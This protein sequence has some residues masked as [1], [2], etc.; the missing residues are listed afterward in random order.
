MVKY[1]VMIYIAMFSAACGQVL[2]KKG[3]LPSVTRK[4]GP[5]LNGWVILGLGAMILSMLL[6]VRGLR[7]VPLRDMV[8]ILPTTYI[9]VPIFSWA[10]L[11][12]PI[13]R[14]TLIGTC[15]I[16]IGILLFNI[17]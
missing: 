6:N 9:L 16:M 4:C 1:Y 10:F 11:K 14:R 3:A 5:A 8:F 13:G 7:Y 2:L 17:I 15:I 12:E